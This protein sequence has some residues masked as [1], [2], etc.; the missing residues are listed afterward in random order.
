MVRILHDNGY[1]TVSVP[2]AGDL[3]IYH[4]AR[5]RLVHSS[6]V[7]AVSPD[8]LVMVESKWSFMGRYLHRVQDYCF[9]TSWTYQH[10]RRTG[11]LLLGLDGGPS[12]PNPHELA[13]GDLHVG[14]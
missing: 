3:A 8:G 5:G 11:H 9:A 13:G 2:Q 4:D 6:V 1:E 14:Q 7:R 10:S 12:E